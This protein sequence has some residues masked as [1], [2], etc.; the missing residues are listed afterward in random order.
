ML[1]NSKDFLAVFVC[2]P[3][4]KCQ[5]ISCPVSI[6]LFTLSNLMTFAYV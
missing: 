4:Y 3:E 6:H 5:L 2:I 1:K